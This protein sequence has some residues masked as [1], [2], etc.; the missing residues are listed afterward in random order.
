M[1]KRLTLMRHAKSAWTDTGLADIERPLN[2]RGQKDAPAIGQ[3]LKDRGERPSL[4]LSSSAMRAKETAR[5]V[6][7]QLG[8]PRDFLQTDSELYLAHPEQ[9]LA[10]LSQLEAGF[11]HILLCAHNPGITELSNTLCNTRIDN[12]PTG[13]IVGIEADIKNWSDLSNARGTL[14]FF[15]SPKALARGEIL[16]DSSSGADSGLKSF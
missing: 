2:Q 3:W 5:I 14:S 12:V 1:L 8:Y 6:A 16:Y 4:I 15:Q 7:D 9:I 11:N 10:V 13:G